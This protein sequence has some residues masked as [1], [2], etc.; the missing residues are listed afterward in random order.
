[1][2]EIAILV[3]SLSLVGV[4]ANTANAMRAFLTSADS[5]DDTQEIVL[6][7]TEEDDCVLSPIVSD[8]PP[9]DGEDWPGC[10][11]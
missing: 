3:L 1:M 8:Q 4:L 2:K 5:A 9:E 7:E 10:R 11:D 6:T